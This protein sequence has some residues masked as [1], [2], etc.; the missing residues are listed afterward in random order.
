[1]NIGQRLEQLGKEIHRDNVDVS[2]LISGDTASQLSDAFAPTPVGR[3]RVKG[4]VGEIDVFD[5]LPA[6]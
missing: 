4:R 1:V 2:I 3:N 6:T 5:L